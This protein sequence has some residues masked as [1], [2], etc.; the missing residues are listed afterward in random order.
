M[1]AAP[2][3]RHGLLQPNEPRS[4]R[5][6]R[7]HALRLLPYAALMSSAG[8]SS[9]QEV[10]EVEPTPALSIAATSP[11]GAPA[12]G[13]A[14]W[15]TRLPNGDIA[16]A[17][18]GDWTVRIFASDGKPLRAFG[19]QGA[20]PGEF[21]SLG[22]IGNCGSDGVFAWD[23]I[24]SRM[25]FIDPTRGPLSTWGGPE[26][27][28]AGRI[29][30]CSSA[31][32]FALASNFRRPPDAQP[33]VSAATAIGGDYRVWF[34]TFDIQTYDATGAAVRLL[35]R[36]HWQEGVFGR[37][38][39]RRVSGF[40]R[41]L[42]KKTHFLFSNKLLVVTDSDSGM[43]RTFAS[44]GVPYAEFRFGRDGEAARTAPIHY[45]HAVEQMLMQAPPTARE[46]FGKFARSIPPPERLPLFSQ[47][48]A[49]PAGQLWFVVSEAGA[50]A[51]QIRVLSTRGDAIARVTV[52]ARLMLFEVGTDYILGRTDNAEGEQH[53]VLYTFT[54]R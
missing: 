47:V 9:A 12:Y 1:T 8:I 22:W 17:D 14:T 50:E 4:H 24:L 43:V 36:S 38:P 2:S 45:E 15:A 49:D 39:D 19:R 51:T 32:E 23:F 35:K 6:M 33:A 44:G 18:G 34:D 21:R 27:R 11:T 40:E 13:T 46:Q 30:S 3:L 52:P 26:M 29:S 42:G 7:S 31:G 54:G 37:L 28:A 10:W 16:L 5:F 53:I 20:G 48:L 25:S 41:P